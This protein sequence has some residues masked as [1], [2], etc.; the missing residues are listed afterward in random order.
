MLKGSKV[1]PLYPVNQKT[2][3]IE[4]PDDGIMDL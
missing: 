1:E 4:L 2:D 3:K